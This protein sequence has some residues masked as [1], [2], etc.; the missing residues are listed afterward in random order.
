MVLFTL[1]AATFPKFPDPLCGEGVNLV[2]RAADNS[3]LPT[4]EIKNAWNL[5]AIGTHS[6]FAWCFILAINFNKHKP[7]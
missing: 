5:T 4:E 6:F 7:I 2:G 3:P 1:E